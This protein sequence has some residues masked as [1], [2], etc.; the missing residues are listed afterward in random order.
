MTGAIPTVS[1][2][3]LEPACWWTD[4]DRAIFKATLR[5]TGPRKGWFGR[6]YTDYYSP[7]WGNIYGEGFAWSERCDPPSLR[8]QRK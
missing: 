6:W 7:P 2:T 1:P 4:T 5:V 8:S 3:D